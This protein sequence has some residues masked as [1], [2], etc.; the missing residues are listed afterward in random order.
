MSWHRIS[1]DVYSIEVGPQGCEGYIQSYIIIGPEQGVAIID[2]GPR[3]S[4]EAL[5]NGLRELGID[6]KNVRHIILTHVHL[7]HGG[8]AA[9][10][11]KRIGGAAVYVHPIGYRH[12]IDPGRLWAAAREALG[13][14]AEIYGEPERGEDIVVRELQDGS[15]I[16]LDGMRL[17]VIHTPGHA[18][19][20]L[21][22]YSEDLGVLFVGDAAGVYVPPEDLIYPTT[23]PPFRYQQ[24][25]ESLGK[26]IQIKPEAVAFPH[27]G[28]RIGSS[29]LE[30]ARSQITAW[31]E[32]ALRGAE[33][34]DE[35]LK[36]E[37]NLKRY[38]ERSRKSDVCR[39]V[40]G[41][42]LENTVRG[43]IEE[44]L[45]ISSNTAQ[46]GIRAP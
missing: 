39:E 9:T 5:L 26:M 35:I 12:V 8:G 13:R 30:R 27:M 22:I 14:V 41:K 45:R 3:N 2:P 32:L 20:H 25:L 21:S 1:K 11:A 10:V 16:V 36:I 43:L 17:K 31:F 18:S 44:A 29:V 46:P 23:P 15:E 37:A 19:H 6:F 33:S 4:A 38:L 42:N 7:D 40:E 28:V 24:Y 34:L